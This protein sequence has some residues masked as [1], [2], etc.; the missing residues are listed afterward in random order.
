LARN[1]QTEWPEGVCQKLQ[2]G[3]EHLP[4]K[5]FRACVDEFDAEWWG[6]AHEIVGVL[7]GRPQGRLQLKERIS[8]GSHSTLT[9]IGLQ[10]TVQSSMCSWS[11]AE[12]SIWV[13]KL[14]PHQGQ[15]MKASWMIS[16]GFL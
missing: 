6:E 5:K 11:P 8:P 1:A 15:S 2:V 16:I 9:R 3:V 14:S 12:V 7:P 4:Q 10:H 13:E